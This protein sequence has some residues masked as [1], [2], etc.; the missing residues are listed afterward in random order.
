M[1]NRLKIIKTGWF[2]DKIFDPISQGNC[3][4]HYLHSIVQDNQSNVSRLKKYEDNQ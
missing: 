1:T 3:S 2:Y 4:W